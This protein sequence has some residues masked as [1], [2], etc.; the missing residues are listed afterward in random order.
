M[1]Y[2]KDIL[3]DIILDILAPIIMIANHVFNNQVNP[4]NNYI[5]IM[6]VVYITINL[7]IKN[8]YLYMMLNFFVIGKMISSIIN[9]GLKNTAFITHPHHPI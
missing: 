2:F 4:Q 9:L 7:L 5:A 8:I 1:D 6:M 3:L